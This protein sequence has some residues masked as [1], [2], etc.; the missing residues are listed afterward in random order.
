MPH[1]SPFTEEIY[2]AWDQLVLQNGMRLTLEERVAGWQKLHAMCW[3]EGKWIVGFM[4]AELSGNL[5]MS[6]AMQ[7]QRWSDAYNLSVE[8]LAHEEASS[9]SRDPATIEAY[10]F[11]LAALIMLGKID[12]AVA[13][14][15]RLLESKEM[16]R[17]YRIKFLHSLCGVLHEPSL[18]KPIDRRIALFAQRVFSKFPGCK[19]LGRQ[20]SK[21]ESAEELLALIEKVFEHIQKRLKK[22]HSL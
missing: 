5:G 12:Q 22:R 1:R 21:A 4:D 9:Y 10:S 16:L 3:Q 14:G 13:L 17:Y 8:L 15:T 20:A 19:T 2:L 11:Q 7:Q 18:P 6:L